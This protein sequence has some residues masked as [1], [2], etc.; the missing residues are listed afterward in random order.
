MGTLEG[1][2]TADGVETAPYSLSSRVPWIEPSDVS[3]A[4]TWLCSDAARKV[5]GIC[6]PIDAGNTGKPG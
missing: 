2:V 6:P 5:T 1:I 3:E 4:V